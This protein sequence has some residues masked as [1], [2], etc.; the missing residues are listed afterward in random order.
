MRNFFIL[1]FCFYMFNLSAQDAP[2]NGWDLREDIEKKEIKEQRNAFLKSLQEEHSKHYN[3]AQGTWYI[4]ARAGYGIPFLT[5]NRRNIETYLGVSDYFE[6]AAGEILNRTVVTTDA[7]G[8]RSAFYFGHKINP[9]LAVEMDVAYTTYTNT[10]QG[11]IVSPDYNSQ[12]FSKGNDFSISPQVVLLSPE[13]GN[14]TFYG[15]FGFHFPAYAKANGT[16][17]IDD[18]NGT[19]LKSIAGKSEG[20][21]LNIVDLVAETLGENVGGLG[22]LEDGF[23][24]AIGYHFT[25]ETDADIDFRLRGDAFGY[26]AS[27]GVIYQINPLISVMGEIRNRGYNITTKSYELSNVNGSLDIL[28]INDYLVF[29]DEGVLVEG[30]EFIPAS[31]LQWLYKVNYHYELDENSNNERT[32]PNGIDYTKPSDRLGL[33][34]STFATSFNVGIQ[35]NL[36]GK[37]G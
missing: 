22:F 16:A 30:N 23:F 10:L 3:V 25:L 20:N 21:L 37:K 5:V 17:S 7:R 24:K 6:N 19:F 32:N 8:F 4:G 14:F 34:R 29:T 18:Y 1:V 9:Y 12:L 11:R 28:G 36:K 26:T 35:F 2:V 13:V 15:K 33:R 27:L 31:E